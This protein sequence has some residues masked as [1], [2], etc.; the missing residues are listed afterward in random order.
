MSPLVDKIK[1]SA[2]TLGVDHNPTKGPYKPT[3]YHY[4]L[5]SNSKLNRIRGCGQ[6]KKQ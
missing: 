1:S 3:Y 2:A 4:E 5:L 6:K